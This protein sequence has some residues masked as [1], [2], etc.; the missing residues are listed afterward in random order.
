MLHLKTIY[1]QMKLTYEA[2]IDTKKQVNTE[3]LNT[4]RS[5]HLMV[6][7]LQER[8]CVELNVRK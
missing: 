3:I 7:K 6:K 2:S 5:Y 4:V 1:C 8:I